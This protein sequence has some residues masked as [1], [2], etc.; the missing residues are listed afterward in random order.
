M[1]NFIFI[2]VFSFP[3]IIFAQRSNYA[4]EEIEPSNFI[5]TYSLNWQ[6]DSTDANFIRQE[7][8]LLFIGKKT[9]KFTSLNYF[10]FDTIMRQVSSREEIQRL[11]SDL[12][13]PLP[14]SAF[15]IQLFKQYQKEKLMCIEHTLDGTFKY[16]EKL[17][18]FNWKLTGDTATISGYNAQ[19]ALCNFGGREWIAW[20]SPELPFND[21]PYK[22]NG[23][24]GLIVKI[25]DT[26]KHYEFELVSIE[27]PR[28]KLMI[29]YV[30]KDFIEA[31]KHDF[32]RAKDASRVDIINRAKAAG[33]PSESQ[34]KA[35]RNMAKR[36]NPIELKRK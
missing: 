26:H 32:F 36:N 5:V 33:L 7:D 21:G 10:R 27:K 17:N 22:F 25:F 18:L 34:Q 20:F 24:P 29:D 2:L 23:L 30:K 3:I 13:N 14:S 12:Q 16:E 9:S 15:H 19:K 6:Q 35:A 8:M 1:R 11:L 31:T 4:I 28:Q